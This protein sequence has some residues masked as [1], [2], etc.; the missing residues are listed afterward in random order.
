MGDCVIRNKLAKNA[1][2]AAECRNSARTIDLGMLPSS[3][4]LR[5]ADSLVT[6]CFQHMRFSLDDVECI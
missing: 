2:E 3:F 5:D 4:G 1:R 6:L